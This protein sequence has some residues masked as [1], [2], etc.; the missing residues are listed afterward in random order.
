MSSED[1]PAKVHELQTQLND[2]QQTVSATKCPYDNREQACSEGLQKSGKSQEISLAKHG[3]SPRIGLGDEGFH[4]RELYFLAISLLLAKIAWPTI[5]AETPNV[6]SISK[7][8]LFHLRHVRSD[9]PCLLW[10]I[11]V[12]GIAANSMEDRPVIVAHLEAMRHFAG[13]RAIS[14]VSS[15]LSSAWGQSAACCL[16]SAMDNRSGDEFGI[17][18]IDTEQLSTLVEEGS[19]WK[20]PLG[21]DIL[22]EESLLELVIL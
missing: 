22:F 14:S 3:S 17:S 12:L 6:T 19:A 10:A 13:E 8:A 18:P 21:L 7:T 1:I 15:F 5:T 4:M 9:L 20:K 2:L 16:N 11:T